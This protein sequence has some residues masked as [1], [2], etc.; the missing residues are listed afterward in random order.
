MW[1]PMLRQEKVMWL[2]LQANNGVLFLLPNG[3]QCLG[4]HLPPWAE[5][6]DECRA[7]TQGDVGT[8]RER[9]RKQERSRW[10]LG[11]SWPP[12][13]PY[14]ACNDPSCALA[15][16]MCPFSNPAS[17]C[18]IRS[19]V[20]SVGFSLLNPFSNDKQFGL[21]MLMKSKE[22]QHNWVSILSKC[23]LVM[24]GFLVSPRYE[25]EWFRVLPGARQAI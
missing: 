9:P 21:Y 17:I 20:L 22:S 11:S 13:Q 23:L 6:L 12:S 3:F 4:I 8:A 18:W 7:L 1:I 14:C 5:W 15:N 10:L 16:H 19:S 2:Q 25:A 24:R